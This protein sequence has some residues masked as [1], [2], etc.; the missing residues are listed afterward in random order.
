LVEFLN[1]SIWAWSFPFWK[2]TNIDSILDV[3]NKDGPIHI[4]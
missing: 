1:Q 2:V 4:V 3:F